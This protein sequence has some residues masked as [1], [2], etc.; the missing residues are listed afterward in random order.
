MSNPHAP[1]PRGITPILALALLVGLFAAPASHSQ[2][3]VQ[4]PTTTYIVPYGV[5]K[6]EFEGRYVVPNPTPASGMPVIVL[7][8]DWMGVSSRATEDAQQFANMGYAVFVADPYGVKNKPKNAAQAAKLSSA[9]KQDPVK[10]RQIAQAAFRLA[11]RQQGA[12][13]TRVAAVGFCFGGVAALELARSGA[14]LKGVAVV[15]G[16]L[17]TPFPD[18]ARAI[19]GRVLVLHGS[20]DPHVPVSEVDAFKQEMNNAGV[21]FTMIEYPGAMHAFTNPQANDPA[22]GAKYDKTAAEAAFSE[23]ER[24]FADVLGEGVGSQAEKRK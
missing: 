17:A 24:F 12:D 10:L 19:T 22:R 3:A 20:A 2:P 5:D 6:T 18:D 8:P 16:N 21:N 23:M 4:P 9:L 11:K 1:R 14:D 7:F 13:S 15:H